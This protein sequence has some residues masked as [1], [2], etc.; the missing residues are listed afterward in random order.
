MHFKRRE[1]SALALV[2]GALSATGFAP[3]FWWPMTLFAFAG[4]YWLVRTSK[5][6][7]KAAKAGY[8]FG[9]G[10]YLGSMWWIGNAF[11]SHA[12]VPVVKVLAIPAVLCLGAYLALYPAL[13]SW[14]YKKLPLKHGV[15]SAFIFALLWLG[16]EGLRE[17]VLYGFPWNAL[18]YIFEGNLPLM[19]GA[20]IVGVWGLTFFAAALGALM[21]CKGR[22]TGAAIALALFITAYGF[23]YYRLQHTEQLAA[24]GTVRLVQANITQAHK[25]DPTKRLIQLEQH[26]ALSQVEGTSTPDAIIWPE[27]A[28]AFF[29]NRQP[30][31]HPMLAGAA[32]QSL[33]VTG[34]PRVELRE[35]KPY[36]YNSIGVL[37]GYANIITYADKTL[38]VPFGEFIPLRNLIPG[39]VK[40][41]TEGGQDFTP[42][43]VPPELAIGALGTAL[44]LICYEAIFPAFT[45]RNS[46]GRDFILNVTNDGWF[47]HTPGPAQHFAMARM[48]TVETGLPL[49][50]VANTG[51]TA[52]V[53]G[54]G[55]IVKRLK[56]EQVGVLDSTIPKQLSNTPFFARMMSAKP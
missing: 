15:A 31:L 56:V 25:W 28:A 24:A 49:V 35:G 42:A 20:S 43:Q 18:G 30:E 19:Q 4:L 55:R 22:R 3:L 11:W 2:Y 29:L 44:P 36:F 1:R 41:L 46:Y 33:L 10:L 23:G 32:G 45:A 5:S 8:M 21:T 34:M 7:K 9:L 27:T 26:A 51:I 53:D 14:I 38:L 17:I 13:C 54:Y 39:T 40:K 16:G 37:D 6:P 50:R 12:P 52:V 48:R 47:S